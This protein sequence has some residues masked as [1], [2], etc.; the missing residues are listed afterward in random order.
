M[1]ANPFTETRVR[2]APSPTGYLHVGGAR[3]ALY[4]YLYA[5]NQ[6]G[7]FILR[8]EDT[9]EERSTEESMKMQIS[10]LQWLGLDWDEGVDPITL[11]DRGDLGP[12]RQ[13][14]RKEI[15]ARYARQLLE[16]GQ[17]YYCFLTDEEIEKQREASKAEG[18][19]LRVVS[20]YRDLSLKEAEERVAQGNS[21]VVRFKVPEEIKTYKILDLVRGDVSWQSDM[22]GDFVLL[23]S[24]GMPVYNFCCVVD[25]ALMR[26]SHVFRAE[27]HLNNTLRQMMLYEAL[28]FAIPQFAHMS[29]IL[30][31]D[32][33]KLSKRHGATSVH[34]F[35]LKGY[36]PAAINNFI[37]LLGWSSPAGAEILSM[38][39]MIEQFTLDRLN[40]APAVF[41]NT[42]LKWVN[43]MHLRAL[44]HAELWNK[45]A[46]FLKE[47]GLNLPEDESW[48]DR[49]LGLLKVAME[50][51]LDAV[52]L[53]RPL[54]S[55]QFQVSE[56]AKE[57][58]EWE[59]TPQVI[60]TWKTELENYSEAYL[61]EEAFKSIQDQVK[62]SAGVKG[63]Q[64]F[65]PIRVA[66]IGKA[67]GSDLQTLVQL[68]PKKDLVLRAE[69]V[70]NK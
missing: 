62:N 53:Y 69:K 33:Q 70:L 36:S 6:N 14:H 34:D 22:V 65:Q 50:T 31:E 45:V 56:D 28:G 26:I 15:Y 1:S 27:E 64:L 20:P 44:P 8:V 52:E 39:E 66:V 41:D 47:A 55:S 23:R 67:S 17:A 25:D 19:A 63:K 12:Y 43:A 58:L 16:R 32:R 51:Y 5:K 40:S 35:N 7:K 21:A 48:R 61:S 60:A 10:D 37:A 49:S 18:G 13:S 11:K 57:V 24:G 59:T 3:T 38:K 2:F 46:P 30:G 68:L 54:D 9:D 42:K 29:F 4:C